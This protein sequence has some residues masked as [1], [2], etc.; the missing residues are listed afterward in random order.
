VKEL[1][2]KYWK[3]FLF[4]YHLYNLGKLQGWNPSFWNFFLKQLLV[5]SS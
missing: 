2:I 1:Q 5:N 4:K 3:W